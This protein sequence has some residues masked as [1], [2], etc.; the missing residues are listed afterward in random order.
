M[1]GQKSRLGVATEP[2]GTAF[3]DA[4]VSRDLDA[5]AA[6]IAGAFVVVIQLAADNRPAALPAPAQVKHRRR[7]FLS[8]AA[9]ERAARAAV[10]RGEGVRVY[11]AELRPLYRLAGCEGGTE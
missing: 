2:T 9:A 5:V 11:L 6:T 7:V 4:S 1:T 8:V 3:D 10:G